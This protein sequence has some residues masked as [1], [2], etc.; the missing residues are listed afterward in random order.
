MSFT[1]T[2]IQFEFLSVFL[3]THSGYLLEKGKEYVLESRL[4]GILQ[5]AKVGDAENLVR[6]LKE[7]PYGPEASSF[8]QAMT[9]NET[10]FFRDNTP[11]RNIKDH[12]LP[13]I[14]SS[15]SSRTINF[16]CAACSSGQE[17]YSL[18]MTLDSV[19]DHYPG[20]S[21]QI[22]ATD[23]SE[24]MIERAKEGL[25]SEFEIGRGLTEDMRDRYMQKKGNQ[26]RISDRL[27][28]MISFA[29][30]NLLQIPRGIG[31]FDVIMC[32]NVFIYFGAEQKSEILKNLY[33]VSNK[34]GY[35]MVGASEVLTDLTQEYD[36][37]PSWKGVYLTR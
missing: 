25:Y 16:W 7:R 33:R 1:I 23:L 32:R 30:S 2:P 13:A 3:K 31:P 14:T 8:L 11:F 18:A 24:A 27:R 17:P 12:I 28:E 34:P 37:H 36:T 9:I 10:M 5:K 29:Q 20:W 35:L 19:R 6:V 22:Y 21:F 26:W 4:N 15:G